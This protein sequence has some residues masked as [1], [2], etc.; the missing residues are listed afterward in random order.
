MRRRLRRLG[1]PVA[2]LLLLGVVVAIRAAQNSADRT[3]C[4]N[5]IRMVGL[6]LVQYSTTRGAYPA[7]TVPN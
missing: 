2:G 3:G 7:G 1:L 4:E 5:N 6:A